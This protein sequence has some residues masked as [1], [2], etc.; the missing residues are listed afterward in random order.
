MP[1]V[2]F[3]TALLAEVVEEAEAAALAGDPLREAAEDEA[4]ATDRVAVLTAEVG[5]AVTVEV[6]TS[7]V[8]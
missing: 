3:A 6:P 4:P 2:P 5:E 1:L 7:T 8:K